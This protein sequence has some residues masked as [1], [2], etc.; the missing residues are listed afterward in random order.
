MRRAKGISGSSAIGHRVVVAACAPG[1]LAVRVQVAL[2]LELLPIVVYVLLSQAA[3]GIVYSGV[4][5]SF[6]VKT[7]KGGGSR[8]VDVAFTVMGCRR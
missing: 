1:H 4:L 8:Q 7:C 6:V 2:L 3:V 5:V